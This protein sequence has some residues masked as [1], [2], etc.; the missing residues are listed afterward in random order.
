MLKNR[1][2]LQ[3]QMLHYHP[4]VTDAWK[5]NLESKLSSL[6]VVYKQPAMAM[7]STASPS[8]SH[9][10]IHRWRPAGDSGIVPLYDD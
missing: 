4:W 2:Y 6:P 9:W 5:S 8:Q 3:E 1:T 10:D 7:F